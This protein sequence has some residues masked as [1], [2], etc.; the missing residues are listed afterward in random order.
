MTKP[1][2][3]PQ[4][5][6]D[7]AELFHWGRPWSDKSDTEWIARSLLAERNRWIRRTTIVRILSKCSGSNCSKMSLLATAKGH[8][9]E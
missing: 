4:D 6:W 3:I 7:A 8:R 5:V 1:D 2:D 9:V